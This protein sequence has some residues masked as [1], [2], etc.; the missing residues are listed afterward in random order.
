MTT[1]FM[2]VNLL[3]NERAR[4]KYSFGIGVV[5][6]SLLAALTVVFNFL[7]WTRYSNARSDVVTL[8]SLTMSQAQIQK[9]I[10]TLQ[11]SLGHQTTTA[12]Y[13]QGNSD[14][15]MKSFVNQVTAAMPH[16]ASMTEVDISGDLVTVNGKIQSVRDMALYEDA[17]AK[18]KNVKTVSVA[19]I[20]ESTH[21]GFSF[22]LTISLNGGNNQ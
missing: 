22:V 15:L 18:F 5:S 16:G 4:D 8:N 10:Q 3:P 20:S 21:N 6:F 13:M 17:L 12:S 2:E 19:S 1:S 11:V 14:L 9:Q 7:G